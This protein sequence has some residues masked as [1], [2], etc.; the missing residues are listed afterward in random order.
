MTQLTELIDPATRQQLAELARDLAPAKTSELRTSR[1]PRSVATIDVRGGA[2][3]SDIVSEIHLAAAMR[4]ENTRTGSKRFAWRRRVDCVG[5]VYYTC[6]VTWFGR[7]DVN[8]TARAHA[9]TLRELWDVLADREL[10]TRDVWADDGMFLAFLMVGRV[11]PRV[12]AAP[13]E[14]HPRP[15]REQWQQWHPRRYTATDGTAWQ[16]VRYANGKRGLAPRDI[17]RGDA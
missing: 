6:R 10:I 17:K 2:L 1:A 7:F 15:R 12:P 8:A 11:S 13:R 4:G 9:D 3:T 16:L 5:R 14:W